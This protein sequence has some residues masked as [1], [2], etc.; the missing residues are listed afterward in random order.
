MGVGP[1]Q[2]GT[3]ESRKKKKKKRER[4]KGR[5]EK[6]RRGASRKR[7]LKRQKCRRGGDETTP[8]LRG[9]RP[10]ALKDVTPQKG[11]SVRQKKTGA[12]IRRVRNKKKKKSR[13]KKCGFVGVLSITR[14]EGVKG[15][16]GDGGKRRQGSPLSKG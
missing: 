1:G 14:E 12:R 6:G 7:I 15:E 5:S 16:T 9:E 2:L 4:A 10:K 13:K 8:A 3:C 11:G